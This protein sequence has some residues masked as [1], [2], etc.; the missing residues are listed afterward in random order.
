MEVLTHTA[1]SVVVEHMIGHTT[2][3]VC[4]RGWLGG[5][6]LRGTWATTD[7]SETANSEQWLSGG[8]MHGTWATTDISEPANSEQ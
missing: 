3:S 8:D 2:N 4:V 7:I 1:Q 5:G 6:D